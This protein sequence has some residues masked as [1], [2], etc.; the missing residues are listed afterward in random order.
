MEIINKILDFLTVCPVETEDEYENRLLYADLNKRIKRLQRYNRHN[1]IENRIKPF[2]Q[3]QFFQQNEIYPT[4][5]QLHRLALNAFNQSKDLGFID[6]LNNR[7]E[8]Y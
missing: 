2:L 6:C 3:E 1:L 4:P 7:V 5:E 8:E